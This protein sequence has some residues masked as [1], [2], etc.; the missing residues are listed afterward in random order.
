MIYVLLA[1]SCRSLSKSAILSWC[2]LKKIIYHGSLLSTLSA[3]QC[4]AYYQLSRILVQDTI[5]SQVHTCD[6]GAHKVL[7]PGSI[8]R[9]YALKA[10]AN[11]IT[12]HAMTNELIC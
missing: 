11:H 2:S 4:F 1:A 8:G 3:N 6:V 5:T 7:I 10:M 9:R 12:S